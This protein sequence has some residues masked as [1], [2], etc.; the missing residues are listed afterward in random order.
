MLA[1]MLLIWLSYY[2]EPKE[3]QI[4][5]YLERR[6]FVLDIAG[7]SP[8]ERKKGSI[9]LGGSE[10]RFVIQK[11]EVGYD[12]VKGVVFRWGDTEAED[13]FAILLEHDD[14]PSE[15]M[16]PFSPSTVIGDEVWGLALQ[17]RNFELPTAYRTNEDYFFVLPFDEKDGFEELQRYLSLPVPRPQLIGKVG[18]RWVLFELGMKIN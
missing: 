11:G 3:N 15:T 9:L 14:S 4:D 1:L 16:F 18:T 8:E 12:Q 7:L 13:M 10:A 17:D 5:E 6:K 2:M